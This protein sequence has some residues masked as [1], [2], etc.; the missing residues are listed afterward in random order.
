MK[1]N[2]NNKHSNNNPNQSGGESLPNIVSIGINIGAQNTIYSSFSKVEKYFISQVLL[3]DVSSRTI[4]SIIVYTDDHRLYGEPAKASLKRFYKSSYI[5]L[6][7]LI[8]FN[9]KSSFYKCEFLKPKEDRKN[10]YSFSYLGNPV[11]EKEELTGKFYSYLK[12]PDNL[13][14]EVKENE[15]DKEN[16]K[17][18][19]KK[20]ERKK[21]VNDEMGYEKIESDNILTDFLSL[22]N[23]FYF[24]QQ[25]IKYDRITLS[26]P[27]YFTLFQRKRMQNILENI[28]DKKVIVTSESTA[29]TMYYG[30][31]KYRDMFIRGKIGV[32][33]HIRKNIIFIDIG[34]SKTSFIFSTFTYNEFK[35][36][37]VKCLPYLGGRNL[38]FIILK[39]LIDK[40]LNKKE[41]KEAK[42]KR[43]DKT[44][45]DP[46]IKYRLL[47]A[48]EK[49]RKALTVN[50]DAVITVDSL[51]ADIDLE[52][53]ITKNQFEKDI[54]EEF[55]DIFE[56]ELKSF[57]KNIKENFRN[58]EIDS[59][60][61]CGELVRTPKLQEIVKEVT[62]LDISKKILI[63][64][65]PSV[66][67][68][69]YG[70]Y[71]YGNFPINTFEK[72]YEYNY[73]KYECY[74][75]LIPIDNKVNIDK[76][77]KIQQKEKLY[78]YLDKDYFDHFYLNLPKEYFNKIKIVNIK[79]KY[80]DIPEIKD[81]IDNLDLYEINVQLQEIVKLNPNHNDIMKLLYCSN[82]MFEI[83]FKSL[84][85]EN[86]KKLIT[87]NGLIT[88]KKLIKE[89][90]GELKEQLERHK[91]KDKD[92]TKFIM[93][94]NKVSIKLYKYKPDIN[95]LNNPEYKNEII[96][97]ERE[98]RNV[99]NIEEIEK[100]E[101]KVHILITKTKNEII[102]KKDEDFNKRKKEIKGEL[103]NIRKDSKVKE[104]QNKIEKI[105]KEINQFQYSPENMKKIEDFLS[106]ITAENTQLLLK[107]EINQVF[108]KI[109]LYE[110][111][112]IKK[113][114][115][116]V[117]NIKN[118]I[119][120]N[121]IES[122][123]KSP[124][125]YIQKQILKKKIKE[126]IENP[127]KKV[128]KSNKIK[129]GKNNEVHSSEKKTE[130]WGEKIYD[131][132]INEDIIKEKSE[133]YNKTLF[134]L[135]EKINEKNKENLY[136]ILD[137][138]DEIEIKRHN[139]LFII[140][141][142]ENKLKGVEFAGNKDVKNILTY[143]QKCKDSL[144]ELY[145]EKVPK[146]EKENIARY[147]RII[148]GF[149]FQY[150]IQNIN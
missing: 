92:Y 137:N 132:D 65:C 109:N 7:R 26:I 134:D 21:S 36:L 139:I 94:K 64:E 98:L 141:L 57:L 84:L 119:N 73:Y 115:K 125:E 9:P 102:K 63:D 133:F 13:S 53:E 18:K 90:N 49:T 71:K 95:S 105:L 20:K 114:E 29:I 32:D 23:D 97:I 89:G 67:A 78:E 93:K 66:G 8:G 17:E 25:E 145:K 3:S 103:E 96:E 126:E 34:Y 108:K 72:F 149:A 59:I 138:Y 24:N 68:A 60:E 69:L 135:Y 80:K 48:I 117:E 52:E 86:Y 110:N 144:Y 112:I 113:Y 10:N 43:G 147:K 128:E 41:V 118:E 140:Y 121:N 91:E 5:N 31:T 116:Y 2:N 1:T 99:K 51:Y 12:K 50:K 46:K 35:V 82:D 127:I 131:E 22:L 76:L 61:M 106:D 146:K 11:K 120:K 16:E 44:I 19:V 15:K 124:L 148:D 56:K 143:I 62:K 85:E 130:E 100:I 27:D 6:S 40:F 122:F 28:Q 107:N 54:K 111:S 55:L 81:F 42:E 136:L 14:E 75:E 58:Y 83:S 79:L 45:L 104:F 33:R 150:N 87:K 142:L 30:Y 101:N 123:K 129:P 38:D 47:E 37:N 74:Q 70:Y 88:E 39:K 4:P 77:I